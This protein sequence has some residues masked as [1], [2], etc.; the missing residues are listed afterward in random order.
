MKMILANMWKVY[1]HM[2]KKNYHNINNFL[3][4]KYLKLLSIL[5]T[6]FYFINEFNSI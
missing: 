3:K 4:R 2:Y 5:N 1:L 6:F